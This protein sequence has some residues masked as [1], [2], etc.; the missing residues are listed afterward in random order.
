MSYPPAI[1]GRSAHGIPGLPAPFDIWH[2]SYRL[3]VHRNSACP[4]VLCSPQ[5]GQKRDRLL[6]AE[7]GHKDQLYWP[8]LPSILIT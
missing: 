2:C 8:M 4:G 1:F 5:P 7:N 6:T 3:A